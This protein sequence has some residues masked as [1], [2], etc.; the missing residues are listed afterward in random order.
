MKPYL[1]FVVSSFLTLVISNYISTL[2]LA[3]TL[4]ALDVIEPYPLSTGVVGVRGLGDNS[5]SVE[6]A[7][8]ARSLD[9][10]VP[11]GV[12]DNTTCANGGVCQQLNDGLTCHCPHRILWH[13]LP[14]GK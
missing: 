6:V 14:A 12:C 4:D 8:V 10:E 13:F 7:E 9:S 1:G 3:S 5:S 11:H 2:G